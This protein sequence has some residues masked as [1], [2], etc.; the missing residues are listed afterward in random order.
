MKADI[1]E[2]DQR[3]S[4]NTKKVTNYVVFSLPG[5]NTIRAEISD[6]DAAALVESNV[7]DAAEEQAEEEA[8]LSEE[9]R[10]VNE[11]SRFEDSVVAE[12]EEPL[13]VNGPSD[14]EM[15]DWHELDEETLHPQVKQVMLQAG[16][17]RTLPLQEL[18]DLAQGIA[19]QLSEPP[20]PPP[21][22]QTGPS[23]L[24][25]SSPRRTV[26]MDAAGNPR[27][28]RVPGGVVDSDP[29]EVFDEDDGVAQL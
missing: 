11:P 3:Y 13:P 29:G 5:G 18:I 1:I 20:P 17:P 7:G 2:L 25:A 26:P 22:P 8:A 10:F 9:V 19:K 16:T 28:Q 15:V 6:E 24:R 12:D 27:V 21:G 14:Q 23:P 4:L